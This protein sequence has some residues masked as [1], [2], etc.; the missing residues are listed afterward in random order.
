MKITIKNTSYCSK[1][2]LVV[3]EAISAISIHDMEKVQQHALIGYLEAHN[4]FT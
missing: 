2:Y 3:E 1:V 4:Q